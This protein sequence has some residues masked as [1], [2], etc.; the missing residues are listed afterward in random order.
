[1]AISVKELVPVAIAACLWGPQWLGKHICFHSD[2]M[3]VMAVLQRISAKSPPLHCVSLF[4]AF[5]CFHLSARHVLG[6]LNGV[7]DALSRNKA[8]HVSSIISQVPK[9][10]LP[11][12]LH[13]LLI[14]ERPG[15]GSQSWT[16]LFTSSLTVVSS[17]LLR[18]CTSQTNIGSSHSAAS[19]P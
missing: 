5:Y 19:S 11:D 3:A 12:R 13:R 9:F 14:S 2:N 15:W 6:V 10:Q 8:A 1:M 18:R 4:S 7:A 17:S 16:E